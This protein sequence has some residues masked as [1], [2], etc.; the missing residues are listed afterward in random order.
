MFNR[1]NE[2]SMLCLGQLIRF[3]HI[4]HVYVL[5]DTQETILKLLQIIFFQFQPNNQNITTKMKAVMY[6]PSIIN[7]ENSFI[8]TVYS[9]I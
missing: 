2:N 6:E 7:H 9:N 3:A 5:H 8:I 1:L 4:I